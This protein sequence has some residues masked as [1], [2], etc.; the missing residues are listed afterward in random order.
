[1]PER[2]ALAAVARYSLQHIHNGD[3]FMTLTWQMAMLALITTCV[4][5]N[6]VAQT[7]ATSNTTTTTA[8]PVAYQPSMSD[9]MNIG[10]QPRHIKLW[11]AGKEQNWE[12]AAYEL[13][14]LRGAFT[15]VGRTQPTYRALDVPQVIV[16]YT[17][18]SMEA[19]DLA[20]KARDAKAFGKAYSELTA[21]CNACHV[22][23]EHSMVVIKVPNATG[24]VDQE[25]RAA[26]R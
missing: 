8:I 6:L 12:Y 17:K 14:E 15:R 22:G 23:A 5:A 24:F 21:S 1:M 18:A 2:R 7:A 10:V 13:G 11:M 19:L 4:G 9:L 26:K 16:A 20:I 3:D 25:F